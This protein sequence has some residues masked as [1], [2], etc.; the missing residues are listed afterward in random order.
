MNDIFN[1]ME[2]YLKKNY[3]DYEKDIKDIKVNT[4]IE[5]GNDKGMLHSH[6]IIKIE[7]INKKHIMLDYGAIKDKIREDLGITNFYIKNKV[8]QNN[9]ENLNDYLNKYI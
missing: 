3:D 5:R 8:I 7:H 4:A 2:L 9:I 6:S 1:N